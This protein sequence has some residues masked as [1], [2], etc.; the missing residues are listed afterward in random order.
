[1]GDRYEPRHRQAGRFS[2][3]E[4]DRDPPRH[5]PRR[6]LRYD[7]F[8][9]P[10]PP[11]L[12]RHAVQPGRNNDYRNSNR[13]EADFTFRGAAAREDNYRPG[14]PEENFSFRAQGPQAPRFPPAADYR[15]VPP[16]QQ[17]RPRR[18][19]EAR[20][21]QAK[22]PPPNQRNGRTYA[23]R[24]RGKP[25]HRPAPH[26]RDILQS[27]Y[28][29][30]TPEQLEGMD[31][32]ARFNA[33][34]SSSDDDSIVDLTHDTDDEEDDGGPRKR[35]KTGAPASA[36]S[37]APK[38]S[39]VEVYDALPPP[40]HLGP[41][42][43]DI[44]KAIRKAKVDAAAQSNT[45]NAVKDNADFISFNFDEDMADDKVGDDSSAASSDHEPPSNAPAGP[46]RY[47]LRG[48]ANGKHVPNGRSAQLESPASPPQLF[49]SRTQNR[50]DGLGPPPAPPTGFVMPSDEELAAQ[51]AGSSNRGVNMPNGRKRKHVETSNGIGDIVPEWRSNGTNSTPWC[52]VDHTQTAIPAMRLHKEICDFFEFVRPH[53][54]EEAVR[55]D[56]IQRVQEAVRKSPK[57]GGAG[58]VAIKSFGSFA[59]GLYL[60]IADMDLVAVSPEYL[61]GGPKCFCQSPKQIRNLGYWFDSRTSG[62]AATG[63]MSPVVKARVPIVKFTDKKT[64]IKVDVSFENDSG[65]V[66]NKTVLK[67]KE[68]YPAMPVIVALIKQL[69][70]MR[71]LNEVFTGGLGGF[72]IICLVVSML[73]HMPELD[74]GSMDPELDYANLLMNFLDLYGNRFN[75]ETTG[76]TLDPPGYIDKTRSHQTYSNQNQ[77][78]TIIDPNKA[79]NDLSGGSRQ[80]RA[81]LECFSHAHAALQRRL[82]DLN[83]GK[84]I[85]D[86]VLGC[87]LG[88]N[89][90]SFIRQRNKLSMIHRG[91]AVS[92]PP[93]PAPSKRQQQQHHLPSAPK[94]QKRQKLGAPVQHPLPPKPVN[95]HNRGGGKAKGYVDAYIDLSD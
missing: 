39:N 75:I 54:Y 24:G 12:G 42:K 72:S 63:T 83:S 41:P 29:E 17:S 58:T 49:A 70:A 46:A 18:A 16:P 69:L 8:E 47:R 48:A 79:D 11:L 3:Y 9:R 53:D 2:Q 86:S 89:Y 92:P 87:I 13:R 40:D 65:L 91:H 34:E 73:Q 19:P 80:I 95:K 88:G 25:F 4:Y 81:I 90:S 5:D 82:A 15:A 78:L 50:N 30:S 64:G 1:M 60:P 93:A 94:P 76:I 6:D 74:S 62:L 57:V 59:S 37:A 27:T 66:G 35:M 38:W 84:N 44:V 52:I 71:N 31:G 51:M 20:R 67:W 85:D 43:K 55:R 45:S 36:E 77:N 10:Q 14:R 56:L 22:P 26:E 23:G 32:H 21:D 7:R 68:E 28:R 61:R 33:I